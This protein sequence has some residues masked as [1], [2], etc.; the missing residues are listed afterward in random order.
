MD[1]DEKG[2]VTSGVGWMAAGV[3]S[4]GTSIMYETP[5]HFSLLLIGIFVIL[6]GLCLI[7]MKKRIGKLRKEMI[8]RQKSKAKKQKA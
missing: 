2:I 7:I 5:N 8:K 6:V 4:I 3:I 1:N